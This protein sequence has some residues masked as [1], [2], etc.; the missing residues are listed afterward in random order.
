MIG[1]FLIFGVGVIA[2][3]II[4]ATAEPLPGSINH[5]EVFK[6]AHKPVTAFVLKPPPA[7][8]PIEHVVKEACVSPKPENV[9]QPELTI[10]DDTQKPRR[11]RRHRRHR[12]YW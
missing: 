10:A 2:G 4:C 3:V 8:A 7:P 12:R 11:H 1:R 9:T 6:V 5:C